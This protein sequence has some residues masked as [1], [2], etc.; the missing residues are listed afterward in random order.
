[1][2][3]KDNSYDDL[4]G[5][6]ESLEPIIKNEYPD[7]IVKISKEQY[8]IF[9]LK[10]MLEEKKTI[11]ID[12]EFQRNFVW[13]L[14]QEREL[15]ESV[16][17]GIPLP[18]VYMFEEKDGRKQVVDGRQ[19]I[20]SLL[21]YLNNKFALEDLKMLPKFNGKKFKDL[22]PIFQGKIESYQIHA[23]IIEPPTSERVKYD[24]F[25]RVNR[26]GTRLNNQEMRN[27][28]YMGQSTKLIKELS[29][30]DEFK[31]ATG[32][33]IKPD[34]MKDRYI[35]LRFLAFYLQ[36][37]KQFKF[38]Y[39]SD[40][41]NFLAEAMKFINN[42]TK[43]QIDNL[44]NIFTV[45]MQRT[46]EILGNNAFRFDAYSN[47]S[48]KR[49]INMALFEALAYFFATTETEKININLLKDKL[50]RL[51]K[52]FDNSGYFNNRI[53]SSTGVDYRFGEVEKLSKEIA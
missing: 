37:T 26:G 3:N 19:R 32:D 45:A 11:I 15:V 6:E 44:A 17:M 24:I 53:D 10:R 5:G 12:P 20:T 29:E 16:L 18:V 47:D 42:L 48:N 43:E 31:K 21:R 30:S 51:K 8:S 23:Y 34:R 1:M 50:I 49:P 4:E 35:I 22:E 52:Q 25:D 41:D 46:F 28:L 2:G 9:E 36:R 33:S 13:K 39:K 40:I 27:A 14:P 7:A 38:G